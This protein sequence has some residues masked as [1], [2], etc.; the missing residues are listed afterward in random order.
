MKKHLISLTNNS[1]LFVPRILTKTKQGDQ[2]KLELV[3]N[4][5]VI[6]K[7]IG[8]VNGRIELIK[9]LLPLG[10][11]AV[12]EELEQEVDSLVGS[13]YSRNENENTRWGS[14]PGSVYL[15]DQKL[16]IKVPRVRNKKTGK[17]VELEAY[18][19]FK[20]T[21]HFNE[22]VFKHL[23]HGISTRNYE[24]VA[25]QLPVTF[26]IKKSSVSR[27]FKAATAKK[28]KEFME[29][30]LSNEDIIAIFIDGKHLRDVQMVIALG[31]TLQG[32]KIPLGFIETSTENGKVCKEFI[33]GL[34]D[35]G[36]NTEKEILFIVDGSKGLTKGIKSVLQDKAFIQR[37]QWHKREN[38]LSYLPKNHKATFRKKL[39]RAYEMPNYQEAK[40][41]LEK[42]KKELLILNKSAA[43]SLEEGLEE[44]LTLHKLGIF[45]NMGRSFKTTNC[46][47]NLN[48]GVSSY[49]NR[50]CKWKNSDQ[51]HRWVASALMMM[52]PNFK[53]VEGFKQLPLLRLAMAKQN[54]KKED[55]NYSENLK[56]A[57]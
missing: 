25:E 29:R 46:I 2:M 15:G 30:D 52:E 51:R 44:T 18:K 14:N 41:E 42:V 47:E 23:V 36:L 21:G 54:R 6:N 49:V 13:K 17:E 55:Y 10:L 57:A 24:K 19:E 39:Q 16:A 20:D 8:A 4:R 5:A 32:K 11:E 43:A 45:E 31:V 40:I 7:E 9:Q 35:R 53:T 1:K 33:N 22:Q 28:L 38:V 34:V 48:R 26:G 50:V 27:Q 37:C 3:E 56:I 12:R